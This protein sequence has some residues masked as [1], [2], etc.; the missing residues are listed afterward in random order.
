RLD[1]EGGGAADARRRLAGDKERLA[2]RLDAWQQAAER[3]AAP[4]GQAAA[5]DVRSQQLGG[6]MRAGARG[7]RDL[8]TGRLAPGEHQLADALDRV[9]RALNAADA[10]G[11]KGESQ[12]LADQLD[13]VR[14]ARER[15]ARLEKALRDAQQSAG[16]S[17]EARSAK[18][19]RTGLEG[20]QGQRGSQGDG[21]GGG[22]LARLQQEYKQGLERTREL[23]DRLQRGTPESG[24]MTSPEEHEWSRSAPGTEAFKQDYAAWQS[25]SRDVTEALERYEASVA[26]RLATTLAR[27][28]LHAGGSERVPDAYQQRVSKYFESIAKKKPS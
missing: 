24:R 8:K 21:K 23:M 1:R 9:S 11:A 13:Q 12:K 17:A 26:S 15:L 20:R 10:G 6:R 25:L 22:E 7:L 14:E 2:D 5:H 4:A 19:G 27:D 16:S 18:A 28:R 3:Q